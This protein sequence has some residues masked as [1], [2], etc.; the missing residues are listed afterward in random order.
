MTPKENIDTVIQTA[1][2]IAIVGY[3]GDGNK[4]IAESCQSADGICGNDLSSDETEGIVSIDIPS[5]LN[6]PGY[7]SVKTLTLRPQ[8]S[9][10][11]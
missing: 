1:I 7:G 2:N 6:L 3:S 8:N 10:H 5:V 11:I 4:T 9:G